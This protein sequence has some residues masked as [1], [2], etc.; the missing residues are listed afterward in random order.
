[1]LGTIGAGPSQTALV[2]SLLASGTPTVTVALRTPNDLARY[3][4]APVHL[5]TYGILGPSMEALAD[6]LFGAPITGRLPVSIP[7][8]YQVGHG[9]VRSEG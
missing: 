6:A 2:E 9:M 8:I 4:S 5:C 3:P 1:V 7:G